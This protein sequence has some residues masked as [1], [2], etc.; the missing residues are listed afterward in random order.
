MRAASQGLMQRAAHLSYD[1]LS[2]GGIGHHRYKDH[3]EPRTQPCPT[4]QRKA[5]VSRC[6]SCSLTS[7]WHCHSHFPATNPCFLPSCSAPLLGQQDHPPWYPV[8]PVTCCGGICMQ[9]PR[10]QI[11]GRAEA[12]KVPEPTPGDPS[13]P[14][15]RRRPG[16]GTARGHQE[17]EPV[18]APPSS[19]LPKVSPSPISQE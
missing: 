6:D 4:P 9:H 3:A 17:T 5:L 15:S 10:S 14:S 2:T 19:P 12:D 18:P 16:P 11:W 13:S 7:L 1:L 8:T